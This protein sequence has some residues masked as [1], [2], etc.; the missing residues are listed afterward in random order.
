M[1]LA[2]TTGHLF[3]WSLTFIVGISKCL[4]GTI[5]TA[6]GITVDLGSVWGWP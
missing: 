2:V 5:L 3:T 4:S 6:V 1:P